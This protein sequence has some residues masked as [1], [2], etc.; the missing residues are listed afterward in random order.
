MQA[1]RGR[2]DEH[3]HDH[4]GPEDGRD[5]RL[6]P[7]VLPV[8]VL[9]VEYERELVEDERGAR[10][11]GKAAT[12]TKAGFAYAEKPIR[13]LTRTSTRPG[14]MWWRWV[15]PRRPLPQP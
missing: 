13:P 5:D 7:L 8:D 14:T 2:D 4:R 6:P 15:P 9:E 12:S 10:T 11:K 3:Q 1:G